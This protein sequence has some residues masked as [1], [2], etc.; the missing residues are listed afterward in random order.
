MKKITLSLL[1]ALCF[2]TSCVMGNIDPSD[3]GSPAPSQAAESDSPSSKTVLTVSIPA[4]HQTQIDRL[5]AYMKAHKDI[6]I[7]I[8]KYERGKFEMQMQT[9]LMSGNVS[10]IFGDMIFFDTPNINYAV[11]GYLADLYTLMNAD[12]EFSMT[13]YYKNVF[14]AYSHTEKLYYYPLRVNPVFVTV[15][16]SL[17]EKDLSHFKSLDKI[18][19][20]DMISFH[21][22]ADNADL[23]I[24]RSFMPAE[25]IRMELP[26]FIDYE[27]RTCS[28]DSPEFIKI[29]QSYKAAHD[30]EPNKTTAEARDGLSSPWYFDSSSDHKKEK[31]MSQQYML[32]LTTS[33]PYSYF[34]PYKD[35]EFT[36]VIPLIDNNGMLQIRDGES[37]GILSGAENKEAAWD[38]LKYLSLRDST[39]TVYSNDFV[40]PF[41]I[42][43]DAALANMRAGTRSF[44]YSSEDYN[45]ERMEGLEDVSAVALYKQLHSSS[46]LHAEKIGDSELEAWVQ[47]S[48]NFVDEL[49]DLSFANVFA[50]SDSILTAIVTEELEKYLLDTQT[51]EQ[52]ADNI[53]RKASLYLME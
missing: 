28:F 8:N 14:A 50:A 18:S 4:E 34:L 40:Y 37:Y 49:M 11:K 12:A 22:G 5:Q 16:K 3:T 20:M 35:I 1:L 51:A 23:N 29:L 9:A 44:I 32:Q 7:V 26:N 2:L 24:A 31:M 52:T 17:A 45:S 15:N 10:E 21:S 33:W 39:A 43:R 6:E 13:D 38:L 41:V 47:A 48:Q 36:N 27:N 25:Y 53:Q 46:N 42:R 19:I 30:I